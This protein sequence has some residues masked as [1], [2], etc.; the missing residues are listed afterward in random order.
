MSGDGSWSLDVS[1]THTCVCFLYKCKFK[2]D[3]KKMIC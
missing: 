2:S 1:V 3:V